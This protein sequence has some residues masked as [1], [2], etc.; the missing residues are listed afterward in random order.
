MKFKKILKHIDFLAWIKI[1]PRD[2]NFFIW[3][4]CALDV[5]WIYAEM[6]LDSCI[7]YEAISGGDPHYSENG[8]KYYTLQVN[9]REEKDS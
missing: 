6:Y 4:G 2:E 8:V 7:D 1:Y 3:E 9:L 5:P